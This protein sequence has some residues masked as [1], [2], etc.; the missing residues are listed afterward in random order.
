MRTVL[1]LLAFLAIVA[2]A[3]NGDH[4]NTP[5]DDPATTTTPD[6]HRGDLRIAFGSCNRHDRRQDLWPAV[7]ALSADAWVWL[8]DAI[9]ADG[10]VNKVRRYGGRDFHVGAYE[11]QNAHPEYAALTKE[12]RI[13]GTWDDHDYGFNNAGGEWREKDFA[14]KAFLD[15]LGEDESSPRRT[16]A[17]VYESYT[18]RRLGANKRGSVRLILL[19]A[20]YGADAKSGRVL[21][22]DQWAWFE[23]LMLGKSLGDHGADY[24]DDDGSSS[25]RGCVAFDGAVSD[26][27]TD[28]DPV[29][30]T[31]VGSSVQVHAH[32]Q[33][34]LNKM[35]MG[36]D[37]ESWNNYPAERRRLFDL[38]AAANGRTR[39]V[40]LSGD[41]HHS[42]IG[43]SPA[44]CDLPSELVELTSS[45]MTHGLQDEIPTAFLKKLARHPWAPTYL[46]PWLFPNV[47]NLQRRRYIGFNFGELVVDFG[48][49]HDSPRDAG[50]GESSPANLSPAASFG[51]SDE[52]TYEGDRNIE[53]SVILRIRGSDGKVKLSRTVPFSQLEGS[54]GEYGDRGKA[55]SRARWQCRGEAHLTNAQG[56]RLPVLLVAVALGWPLG[57]LL[58]AWWVWREI[59]RARRKR[60]AD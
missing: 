17:G 26:E 51:G 57:F 12:T 30:V 16:R 43:G 14:Q 19:D 42:E 56:W 2:G 48:D 15:F 34:L 54:W 28:C 21:D 46:A 24:D 44:G 50:E 18:F 37:I 23:K 35:G 4:V 22:P 9:Y 39:T 58:A 20:R 33:E 55:V 59:S 36:M 8:G 41:V 1:G 25:D 31:V 45:G 32:T 53:P 11:T 52:Y 60:K 10:K 6:D 40:I 29:D 5:G 47:G 3:A 7:R 38:I 13:L 49:F 27:N